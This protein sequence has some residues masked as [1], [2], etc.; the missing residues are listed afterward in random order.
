MRQATFLVILGGGNEGEEIYEKY[1][2]FAPKNF[3]K[4]LRNGGQ[5]ILPFE[6]DSEELLEAYNLAQKYHMSTMLTSHTYYTTKELS[7]HP[8][9]ELLLPWPLELE[10]TSAE[11][12]GTQYQGGCLYCGIGKKTIGDTYVDRKFVCKYRVGTLI[13]EVFMDDEVKKIIQDNELTGITFDHMLKDYKGRELNNYYIANINSTLP[14][15]SN[16][17]WLESGYTNKQCGHSIIY[18]RSGLRYEREKLANAS[19]FNL[20]KEY[21]NNYQ[22]QMIVVS[23]KVKQIFNEHKIFARFR[24]VDIV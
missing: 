20:T 16:M 11:S 12:Y 8:Y 5:I 23:A 24:P 7:S 10:G 4:W 13:N 14:P 1:K 21:L 19:D 3:Q 9:F 2:K 6:P 18:L 15:L 17:T 22:E